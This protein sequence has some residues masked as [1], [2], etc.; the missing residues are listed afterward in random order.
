MSNNNAVSSRV[1]LGVFFTVLLAFSGLA[2]C[3]GGRGSTTSTS[4]TSAA[5]TPTVSVSATSTSV[6]YNA[7]TDITWSSTNSTSCTFGSIAKTVVKTSGSFNTGPLVAT[8]TYTVTCDD[9]AGTSASQSVTITVASPA[10]SSAITGF[11]DAG[12]G[13]VTVKSAN[14]LTTGVVITIS[15]TINYDGTYTVISQT[16]ND[17]TITRAFV[18]GSGSE[19]GIW[20]L[21]GGMISGCTSLTTAGTS[22]A[23]TL[24]NY[25]S[26]FTGVAPLSVF[27]DTAGTA[28]TP[29]TMATATTRP[30]HDLEYRWD[31]GDPAGGATWS[32]G[33]R[34]GASSKN[35]ATGPVASHVFETPG[36]YIV[37][38][39]ATDGTNTESNS[40]A[41]IVVQYAD[42]IFSGTNTICFSTTGTFTGCPAGATQVTTSNFTT[43]I[44]TYQATNR[45]LLF[46]RGEV[47]TAASSARINTTGP[48]I[49]GAFG[50]GAA[51]IVRMTGGTQILQLSSATTPSIKDWRV[52]DLEFDGMGIATVGVNADGKF[53]QLLALRLNIHDTMRGIAADPNV[54]DWWN[55]DG[56][57][58]HAGH[59]I[60]EDWA[61][62]NSTITGCIGCGG[63]WRI[64][65]SAK[66][67]SI[68]GNMLDNMV[69][70]GSHVIRSEYTGKGVIG[71]NTIARAGGTQH[72]IKLH[73][74]EWTVPGV[75]NPGGVGTYTEQVF[76]ADNKLI[77]ANNAWTVALAPTNSGVDERLRD[78]IV[79]RN[80]LTAGAGT[81]V[82]LYSTAAETTIRNNICDMTGAFIHT[83]VEVTQRGV[84]P[85]PS[86]V[87]VY[88]NTFYSGS[89]GDFTGVN[90]GTATNVTVINNLGSASSAT[91]PV[92][93]SGTGSGI[94]QSNNVLGSPAALFVSAMPSTP[95]DFSLSL[96]SPARDY[97]PTVS[98][99]VWSDFFR[100]D[101]PQSGVP[102]TIDIGAIEGP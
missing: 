44:N 43:A 70:G 51:P 46:R 13:N 80:W 55:S 15:G 92:M 79:E 47:F 85:S 62:I 40:C 30:F 1:L 39:S 19:A 49:V 69:T 82:A 36:T 81:Q 24:Y 95:A 6:A 77:G 102:G 88:N 8:T 34:P 28:G 64:Y 38:V 83:C 45:R 99:P 23:I 61:I 3:G 17:F 14:S 42:A 75:R 26:R 7:S 12:G 27:F 37:S 53:N 21:A 50:A 20:Q 5:T 89:M 9:G 4:S 57:P 101:R 91:S 74:E 71:N 93:I 78:I 76:I 29:G 67:N 10:V 97:K 65:V 33:A 31:F 98:V 66:R 68:Q 48:G 94:I 35:S 54:L 32:Y 56:N 73:A 58:A 52:M 59:T 96:S 60:Y 86:N 11:A 84:E 72:A 90:I 87:R 18:P 16:S 41:K 22:G 100:S 25:P 63:D 2:S